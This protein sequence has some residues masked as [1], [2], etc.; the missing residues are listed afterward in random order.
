MVLSVLIRGH[1][2]QV[3]YRGARTGH[4]YHLLVP[5]FLVPFLVVRGAPVLLYR[6]DIARRKRLPFLLSS[7]VPSLSIVVVITEI[8]TRAHTM[9]S[10]V[11]AALTGAA[12]LSVLLFLTIAGVLS[13]QA[14]APPDSLLE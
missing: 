13:A 7:A 5:A 10:D 14:S 3:R 8:G 11:V 12:R 9:N 1:G 6:E 2:H 4:H